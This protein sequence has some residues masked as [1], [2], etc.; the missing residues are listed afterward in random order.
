MSNDIPKPERIAKVIAAAG[1][2]SRREAES[3]IEQGRVTLNGQ[4]LK[5]PAV[6]VMPT[7][8][9]TVDGRPLFTA[10]KKQPR[11]WVLHKPAGWITTA[12]D[13]QGRPTVF[14]NLPK[15]MGRVISVGRLD[16]NSEGLL[17]L[18]NDGGL[19]R[20]MELPKTGLPREYRVRVYGAVDPDLLME[21]HNGIEFEG[22]HYKSIKATIE[23]RS[24]ANTWLRVVLH[25]GKNREIRQVM[26]AI[27]LQVNR[28]IRIA[29]GPFELGDLKLEEVREVPDRALQTFCKQIGYAS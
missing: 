1:V 4:K 19:A 27:G 21:L 22:V 25:E 10:E 3:L 18:T 24:G 2:C 20:M 9:I 12:R 28:L 15:K 6:T 8:K 11:L 5:T 16:I 26:R 17:L 23:K 14:E 29:Y 7:D 13:P